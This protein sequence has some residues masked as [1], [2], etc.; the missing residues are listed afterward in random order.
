MPSS[1]LTTIAEAQRSAFTQLLS[2]VSFFSNLMDG[3]TDAGNKERELVFLLF[4]RKDDR[5]KEIRSNT[6][7]LTALNPA[8]TTAKGLLE[9]LDEAMKRLDFP[10]T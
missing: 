5:A 2:Q 6:Q 9:C 4:C 7:Y 1:S 3:S 8:S 10:F